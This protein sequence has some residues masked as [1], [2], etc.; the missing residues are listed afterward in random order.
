MDNDIVK[1]EKIGNSEAPP[2]RVTLRSPEC[3]REVLSKGYRY[4]QL[5][6]PFNRFYFA[7]DRTTYQI[8]AHKELVKKLKDKINEQPGRRWVIKHGTIVDVGDFVRTT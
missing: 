6:E 8:E 4:S 2:I 5:S 7:P 3:V 1:C